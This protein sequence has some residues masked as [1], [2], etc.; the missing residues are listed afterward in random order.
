MT[1]FYSLGLIAEESEHLARGG[2]AIAFNGVDS[3]LPLVHINEVICLIPEHLLGRFA[4][5][6]Q[7][8]RL[9]DMA[10]HV[11]PLL[12]A[13]V[14]MANGPV[15]V[16]REYVILLA[17]GYYAMKLDDDTS[18]PVAKTWIP[19]SR[20]TSE[21]DA[22]LCQISEALGSD[23]LVIDSPTFNKAHY[24]DPGVLERQTLLG[25][26]SFVV[27]IPKVVGLYRKRWY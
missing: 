11:G 18:I 2:L 6:E 21:Q 25:V 27:R 14:H 12:S 26:D 3:K 8:K 22:K 23:T 24:I 16:P 7:H 10:H 5:R 19:R 20:Y 15:P 1:C 4:L 9:A 13:I 17:S